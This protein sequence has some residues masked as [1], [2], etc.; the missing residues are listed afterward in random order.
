MAG[1]DWISMGL[2]LKKKPA[3]VAETLGPWGMVGV[4]STKQGVRPQRVRDSEGWTDCPPHTPHSPHREAPPPR[5]GTLSSFSCLL[6]CRE[7]GMVLR[8]REACAQSRRPSRAAGGL[9]VTRDLCGSAQKM[10]TLLS[11]SCSNSPQ[12][13]VLALGMSRHVKLC[14]DISVLEEKRAE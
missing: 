2:E 9:P 8:A 11:D 7:L 5:N 4:R 1:D 3:L 10:L 14:C 13:S 12:V 6:T